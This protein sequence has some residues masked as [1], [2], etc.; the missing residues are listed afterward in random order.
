MLY[1]R[2]WYFDGA[3]KAKRLNHPVTSSQTDQHRAGQLDGK[4]K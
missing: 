4:V 3:E 2:L 1:G